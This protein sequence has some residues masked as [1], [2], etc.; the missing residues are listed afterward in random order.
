MPQGVDWPLAARRLDYNGAKVLIAAALTYV[1][2][3]MVSTL[4]LYIY[5]VLPE[6][7]T[8]NGSDSREEDSVLSVSDAV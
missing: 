5:L 6:T 2:A 4:Q 3:A 1:A 8:S 7:G